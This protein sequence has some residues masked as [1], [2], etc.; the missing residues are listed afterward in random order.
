MGMPSVPPS[1]IPITLRTSRATEQL[2]RLGTP[3]FTIA[4]I[5]IIPPSRPKFRGPVLPSESGVRSKDLAS[6]TFLVNWLTRLII[7][8]K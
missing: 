5:K 6:H 2:F 4:V 8:P 7:M 3:L 1:L